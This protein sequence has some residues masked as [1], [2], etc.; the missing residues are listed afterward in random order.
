MQKKPR[1]YFEVTD[2]EYSSSE[3]VFIALSMLESRGYPGFFEL[4]SV[5]EDPALIMKIIR[6]F[7]GMTIKIPP[8]KEFKECLQAAEYTYL[9]M[10]KH[11]NTNL[12]AK[13]KDICQFMNITPEEEQHLLDIFDDWAKFMHDQGADVRNYMHMN[14]NNTKKRIDMV[15]K[16]KKWTQKNY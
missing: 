2:D 3:F 13:S 5:V 8:I 6:L 7:Y 15:C 4:M 1:G 11:I 16:G 14:R 9:D 12:P 10:H